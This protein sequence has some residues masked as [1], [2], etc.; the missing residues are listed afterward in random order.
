[1]H[2]KA[3]SGFGIWHNKILETNAQEIEDYLMYPSI[4]RLETWSILAVNK[5]DSERKRMSILLRSPLELG[6][7]PMVLYKGADVAML[8]PAVCTGAENLVWPISMNLRG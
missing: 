5:F 1:M 7:I 2:E 6:S 8:D 4:Q 3:G